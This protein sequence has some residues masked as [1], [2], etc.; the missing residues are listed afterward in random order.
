MKKIFNKLY[1]PW[2][3]LILIILLLAFVVRIYRIGELLDFHYDQGRD[4]LVIWDLLYKGK[5]FLIGPT[6]GLAGVFRGPFYYYLIAPFYFLGQGN[7]IY[8]SLFLSLTTV[9]AIW[10]M[11]YLVSKFQDKQSGLIAV[12][13][14][15]FSYF[16]VW[17]S[18][19]LSNPTPMLLLSVVLVWAM[20]LVVKQKQYG[21]YVMSLVSGLSLFSFGSSGELFYIPAILIFLIL[22]WENRPNIKTL[23]VS[24]VLFIFTFSPLLIFDIKHD[25][26]LRTGIQKN[27]LEE[28]SFV[29]PSTQFIKERTIFYYDS[30]SIK[31]FH[32]RGKTEKILLTIF[33]ISFIFYAPALF[34]NKFTKI[35][36]ILLLSPIIGLYFYQGNNNNFYEYYLTGYY[37][38]YITLSSLVLGKLW[39]KKY[40]GKI[41]VIIFVL[42]FLRNNYDPLKFKLT[43][44]TDSPNSIV[45]IN[46]LQAIDYLAYDSIGSKFNVDVYVPPVISY[47]YDYLFKWKGIIQE[48]NQVK[49]L[50]TLYEEDPPHPE[51]LKAWLDR[52]KGIGKVIEEERFGAIT[53]QKRERI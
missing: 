48:E 13:I 33:L 12:L 1:T 5:M 6:T 15:S 46:Q 38:I 19:W 29:I 10:L 8:P 24:T 45:F 14:A 16:M 39:Q 9:L 36:L 25:G 21:W 11:Y 47:S 42:V 37:M 43:S 50:Y 35:I 31:I 51:R 26:I 34:K 41:L 44:N 2:N 27:F 30:F 32:S 22:N 17:T 23:V 3:L 18:R 7:P 20:Y 4:A 28:K 53:V 40:I 52:Q 49:L